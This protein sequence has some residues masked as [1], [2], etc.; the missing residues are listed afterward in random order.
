MIR[1]QN[2][3]PTQP[4]CRSVDLGVPL[5][6]VGPFAAREL[7]AIRHPIGF[8]RPTDVFRNSIGIQT[9]FKAS[10]GIP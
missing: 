7:A 2:L 10:I 5:S 3:L 4:W 9:A 8:R 6:T 1:I